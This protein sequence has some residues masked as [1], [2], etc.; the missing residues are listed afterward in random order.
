M[1]AG[2]H[3]YFLCTRPP[4]SGPDFKVQRA[5]GDK[6]KESYNICRYSVS[7]CVFS[8][9]NKQTNT[10]LLGETRPRERISVKRRSMGLSLKHSCLMD[11]NLRA[12]GGNPS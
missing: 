6:V 7:Q 10:N 3:G 4:L 9:G 8:A 1:L 11:I 12:A 2:G 5:G